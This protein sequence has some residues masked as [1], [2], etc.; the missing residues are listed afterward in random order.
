MH[1]KLPSRLQLTT[2]IANAEMQSQFGSYSWQPL[3]VFC[4]P[5]LV[6]SAPS[7]F[8]E[9]SARRGN[10]GGRGGALRGG[11]TGRALLHNL[12]REE[13]EEEGEKSDSDMSTSMFDLNL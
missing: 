9:G 13:Q 12:A 1:K 4:T 3:G 7:R 2:R 10:L 5:T 8:L 11:L 6:K